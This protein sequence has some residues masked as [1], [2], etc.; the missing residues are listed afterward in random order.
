[1]IIMGWCNAGSPSKHP[2][3]VELGR[4]TAKT[5]KAHFFC[6]TCRKTLY[7]GNQTLSHEEA[8]RLNLLAVPEQRTT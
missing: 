2:I 3:K 6:L 5:V 1:M 4:T 7:G 8:R